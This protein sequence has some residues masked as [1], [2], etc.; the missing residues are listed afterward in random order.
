[1]LTLF[2]VQLRSIIA[3]T[4]AGIL[5]QMRD[6]LIFSVKYIIYYRCSKLQSFR[7]YP[8]TRSGSSTPKIL[9]TIRRHNIIKLSSLTR[10]FR[11]IHTIGDR[12]NRV[13]VNETR[14][15]NRSYYIYIFVLRISL[16]LYGSE[17]TI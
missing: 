7:R 13:T 16:G 10:N 5:S 8:K 11:F 3:S 15:T 9:R 14:G 1:M 4:P 2:A 6:D 17:G 12:R